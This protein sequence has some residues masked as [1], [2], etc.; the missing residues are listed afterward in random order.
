MYR[1]G[2]IPTDGSDLS[3]EAMLKGIDFARSIQARVT[4][5]TASPVSRVYE[6]EPT[7]TTDAHESD[8]ARAERVILERLQP[9]AEYA[10]ANGVEASLAHSFSDYPFQA[11]IDYVQAND[12]DLVF[13]A[14]HGRKGM[15]GLLLG[16]ETQKVLLHSKV[17]VLVSR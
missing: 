6:F 8:S 2:L 5:F 10:R 14:S 17:P 4:L 13:M 9:A 15:V 12:C 11:I 1:N 7:M 3:R 16:S